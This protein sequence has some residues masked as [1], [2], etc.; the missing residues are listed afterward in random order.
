MVGKVVAQLNAN[1]SK[2]LCHIY[3]SSFRLDIKGG[4]LQN[5]LILKTKRTIKMKESILIP[6][7]SVF[8][9]AILLL[10]SQFVN[11]A[12]FTAVASG[13][14]S[15]SATWGGTAPSTNI[16][17]DQ[18]T[19]PVG[20]TVNLDNNTTING[21]LASLNVEG[22]LT[23]SANTTLTVD[24]GSIIGAGSIVIH[25]LV[26][27]AAATISFTGSVAVNILKNTATSLSVAA[28]IVIAETLELAGGSLNLQSGG[29][30]SLSSNGNIEISGGLLVVSGGTLDL[31]NNYNVIYTSGSA[32]EGLELSG[33]GLNN[34]TIDVGGGN[35]VTL[36]SDLAVNGNLNLTSGTLTLSGQDLD[37]NGNVSSTG[38]FVASTSAS[39]IS[40]NTLGGTTDD[41]SFN[42]SSNAVNDFTV[43]VGSSNEASI[44][45]TLTVNGELVL[46]SGALK[47]GGATLILDG[48]V[49]GTGTL[50]GNPFSTLNVT[51]TGGI[52]GSLDFGSGGQIV[53]DFIVNVGSGNSVDLASGLNVQGTLDLM[54]GSHLGIN[55]FTLTIADDGDMTGS[56]SLD[57]NSAS[58]LLI[59]ADDGISGEIRLSGTSIGIFTLNVDGN[60]SVSLGS[61]MHV[62]GDFNLQSGTLVLN[63]NDLMISGD[64]VPSVNGEISSTVG[65]NV[66][67]TGSDTPTG[68]LVFLT[69]TDTVND[70]TID[71][72][73]G[74][75]LMLGSDVSVEGELTLTNG[76][77]NIGSHQLTIGVNGSISG[78]SSTSYIATGADGFL[79][80]HASSGGGS[81]NFPVGTSVNYFPANIELNSGG[82]GMVMVGTTN[83]VYSEGM[84]GFDISTAQ[85]V[86]DAT[87]NIESTITSNLDMDIEL[88]WDTAAE[89]NS[90]SRTTAYISHYINSDWDASTTTAA[91]AEGNG[92]FSIQRN[93][94]TSL[95]PFAVFD[96]NTVIGVEQ[97]A[98]NDNL[99]LY[100][101]PVVDN[102]YIIHPGANEQML[103]DVINMDGR[104]IKSTT[105]NSSNTNIALDD[106]STGIY[107]VNIYNENINEV[108][109]IV[110]R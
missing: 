80:M 33:S 44:S 2:L 76:I 25:R 83:D 108:R 62:S 79:A 40:I 74:S 19:I 69:G 95:S 99:Q 110:K 52:G 93:G 57:V 46:S 42:G 92:M 75:S 98:A 7:K 26:M 67:V 31:T 72:T 104:I 90:F 43:N 50:D 68:S 91:T 84:T 30:L 71:I 100:P 10:G 96:N 85:P 88:M 22:S 18:I 15:S 55:G 37:I 16:T 34:V 54:G 8:L 28:D 49:S 109:K 82:S 21:A 47:Y 89:V 39:N 86:V 53:G 35:T 20:I 66:T 59:N 87:W 36:T 102:L 64:I 17:A 12:N 6:I 70:F 48:T 97:I 23:S 94:I 14:W 13:D 56:G 41:V 1:L 105:I 9:L 11:A 101:N 107:L 5:K 27:N 60:Q 58:G 65:S 3:L 29:D 51:A 73:N 38:G 61:D 103:V 81:M 106:L 77:L 4:F 78:S 24:A 32:I 63:N 45:G